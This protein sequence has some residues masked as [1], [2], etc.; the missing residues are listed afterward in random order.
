MLKKG[1]KLDLDRPFKVEIS[2]YTKNQKRAVIYYGLRLF[3][4]TNLRKRQ[5]YRTH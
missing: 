1:I 2:P 3:F 5:I 4:D